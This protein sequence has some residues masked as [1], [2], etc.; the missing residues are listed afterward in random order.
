MNNDTMKEIFMVQNIYL[1]RAR[2]RTVYGIGVPNGKFTTKSKKILSFREWIKTITYA[3]HL[4][5]GNK[6]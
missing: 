4:H 5:I 3:A 2:S 1:H 6:E